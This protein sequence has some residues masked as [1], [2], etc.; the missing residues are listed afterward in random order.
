MK[1][2]TNNKPRELIYGYQLTE[3]EKTDFDYMEDMEL[4]TFVRYQGMVFAISDFMRLSDDCEESKAGWHGVYGMNAF[5]GV[6][7]KLDSSGEYA[8]MGKALC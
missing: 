3:K 7:I 8:V 2:I 5:C 1:I 6:L 4:E